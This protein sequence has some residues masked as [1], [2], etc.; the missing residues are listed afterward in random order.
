MLRK[1]TNDDIVIYTGYN[2]S[3]LEEK[4]EL[5]SYFKNI[6]INF[7]FIRNREI[8]FFTIIQS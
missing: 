5:L 4:V 3:E 7:Y 1:E 6:I 8:F 2:L